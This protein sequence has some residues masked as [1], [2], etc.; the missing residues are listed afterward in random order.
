[1]NMGVVPLCLLYIYLT[2]FMCFILL[3][4]SFKDPSN[5]KV[6]VQKCVSFTELYL[7]ELVS[8]LSGYPTSELKK[9]FSKKFWVTS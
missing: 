7:A 5:F 9:S 2:N 8:F 6:A 4:L 3:N 1:M